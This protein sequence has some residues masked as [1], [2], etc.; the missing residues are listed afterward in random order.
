VHDQHGVGVH[1]AE[2]LLRPEDL[3]VLVAIV[4]ALAATSMTGL[5]GTAFVV[6]TYESTA[7]ALARNSVTP[8][9]SL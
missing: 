2:E 8:S 5:T 6:A 1:T 9:A 4:D 7:S 3:A